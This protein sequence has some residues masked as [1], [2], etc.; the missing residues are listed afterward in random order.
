MSISSEAVRSQTRNRSPYPSRLFSLSDFYLPDDIKEIFK[1]CKKLVLT[2]EVTSACLHKLSEAPVTK[3]MYRHENSVVRSRYKEH[4]EQDL[5]VRERLLELVFD[6]VTYSNAFVSY[7]VPV[8][9]YLVSPSVHK[10]VKEK[11]KW[12]TDD[13]ISSSE[14]QKRKSEFESWYAGAAGSGRS[15]KIPRR[16]R[17][18]SINW[19][20]SDGAFKGEC[21][22][23][24]KKVRFHRID[25]YYPSR[26]KVSLK[27]WDP[28]RIE[29]EHNELTGKSKYY[30]NMSSDTR[31]LIKKSDRDMFNTVP[32]P[33]I[34]AA[35]QKRSL[36]IKDENLY[37]VSNVKVSGAFPGWGIPRLYSAF[38]LIFYYLTLLKANESIALGKIQ[39]LTILYPAMRGSSTGMD[40]FQAVN[41][42]NFQSHVKG[43]LKRHQ[44]DPNFTGIA[45]FPI[46]STSVYGQ[47]KM[48][49]VSSE[50]EP[51]MRSICTA[52][53]L[54]YDMLFG[55]GNYSGQAVA[56][57]LFSAQTGLHR[58]RFNEL[59]DFFVSR[60]SS[61]LGKNKFPEDISV[62][63]KKYEGPDDV[64]KKQ[65][66]V[67]LGMN[68]IASKTSTL[69]QLD[70]DWEQEM[71]NM[72]QEAREEAEIQ[73]LRAQAKAEAQTEMQ[74]AEARA[75]RKIQQE[76]QEAV[77]RQ[78][79]Q[80]M[81]NQ[82]QMAQQGGQPMGGPQPQGQGGDMAKERAKELYA[83]L[84]QNPDKQEQVIEMAQQKYPQALQYLKIMIQEGPNS[85]DMPSIAAPSASMGG[86]VPEQGGGGGPQQ[87]MSPQQPEQKPPMRQ[88][89]GL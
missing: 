85:L 11:Y 52:M 21:P 15:S 64:Q 16:F 12:A 72:K 26:K 5:N 61:A 23:T 33:Y 71:K 56:Q 40:P 29:I 53:G 44:R 58:E 35:L 67:N 87:Q 54:P 66:I 2:N 70:L 30:Y 48:Q 83:F 60:T 37:H 80:A 68:Q 8:T 79:Q 27:R 38:K 84:E 19:T 49:L 7:N 62:Q 65:A 1:F 42:G 32:W 51:V 74:E 77:M 59:L 28:N 55:G 6:L 43:M 75:Q 36:R 24:G 22:E 73:R 14:Q 25:R 63:L 41:G 17:I 45:P 76:N 10:D 4:F 18:D 86:E 46:G 34:Q 9:R 78:Q 57:R 89:G 69:E 88:S 81:Q 50:L 3:L 47:G 13:S 31:K 82:Q 20:Y 39:D